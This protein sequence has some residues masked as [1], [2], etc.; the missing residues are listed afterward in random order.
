MEPLTRQ[1]CSAQRRHGPGYGSI[2]TDRDAQPVWAHRCRHCVKIMDTRWAASASVEQ[3]SWGFVRP[4][5]PG[6]SFEYAQTCAGKVNAAVNVRARTRAEVAT[7]VF[8]KLRPQLMVPQHPVVGDEQTKAVQAHQRGLVCVGLRVIHHTLT[9]AQVSPCFLDCACILYGTGALW[10]TV[11]TAVE[12]RELGDCNVGAG[13]IEW[14][15][16]SWILG[17]FLKILQTSA[18]SLNLFTDSFLANWVFQ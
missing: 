16:C 4:S 3:Y 15:N 1:Q 5:A 18:I 17:P 11:C 9:Q 14:L 12:H 7:F 8:P 13:Y 6:R 10:R 2:V